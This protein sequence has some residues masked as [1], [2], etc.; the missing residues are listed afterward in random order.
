[1]L[2]V[3]ILGTGSALPPR[4]VGTD[5]IAATLGR[6]GDDLRARTGIE[7]RRWLA[8]GASSVALATEAL[9]AA[10]TRA[11]MPAAA[12]RRVIFVSSCGG[13]HLFPANA[14][15]VLAALGVE[16]TADCFDLNNACLGFVSAFD[17]AA[18]CIV[19]GLGPIGIVAVEHPSWYIDPGEAPRAHAVFGD[20]AAAA[21]L[22]AGGPAEGVVASR[23]A[24]L[25][26]LDG[27]VRLANPGHTGQREDI[28][29]ERSNRELIALA[30]RILGETAAAVLE[31][32][33]LTMDDIRWVA[34]H[35]PNGAMLDVIV[36]RL[37]VPAEKLVRVVDTVGSVGAASIA[38]GLDRVLRERPVSPGDHVLL[39]GVGAGISCGAL[40]YRM[41]PDARWVGEGA[42]GSL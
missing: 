10:L 5:E 1:M 27:S 11:D 26:R 32:A 28:R 23:F 35:Q 12:L 21:V 30:T 31:D 7:T 18:R 36:E 41:G 19:T 34:P 39:V 37:G 2:N 13:D 6:D 42:G 40:I 9:Q 29:F 4:R 20:A 33:G 3:R 25:G 8:P 17:L 22:G 16:G 38:L 14:N 24:N 15:S